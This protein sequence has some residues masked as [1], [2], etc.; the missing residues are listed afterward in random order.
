MSD[1]GRGDDHSDG[2]GSVG[3]GR[4]SERVLTADSV[5]EVLS[6]SR[7]RYLLF[8]LRGGS[9]WSLSEVATKIA[10]W[11]NGLPER[12]VDEGERTR[13]YISLYHAHVPLLCEHGVVTFDETTE[14]I[15][16]GPDADRVVAV[17][18]AAGGGLDAFADAEPSGRAEV[19]DD[20]DR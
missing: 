19:N 3:R 9:E 17:L 20:V 10:A 4:I 1:D 11:E 15:S 13:V 12:A 14:R 18:A 16:P 8:L 5:F 6:D 2:A 7:R